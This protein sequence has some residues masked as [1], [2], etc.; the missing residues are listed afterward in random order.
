MAATNLKLM[1]DI[2]RYTIGAATTVGLWS[3]HAQHVGHRVRSAVL[4]L[5]SDWR[6]YR[7]PIPGVQSNLVKFKFDPYKGFM[8]NTLQAI[9]G[10]HPV[11]STSVHC[12]CW[13]FGGE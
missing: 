5:Y 6:V 9:A 3:R 10:C 2:L 13:W 1:H 7:S 4:V 11:P 8:L 12:E